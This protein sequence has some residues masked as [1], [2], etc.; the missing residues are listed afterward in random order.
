MARRALVLTAGAVLAALWRIHRRVEVTGSSM[1]PALVEGDRLLVLW[2]PSF[3]PLRRGEVV[4]LPDP[5]H[6]PHGAP[7]LVKRVSGFAPDG[8]IVRGDNETQSTDSA[9][10]GPV[11]RRSIAGRV[12]YRYGPPTRS[13]RL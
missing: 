13:G 7:M 1:S 8:V 4:A 11:P 3:W 10:F 12:V 2:V 5:R 9:V 6:A